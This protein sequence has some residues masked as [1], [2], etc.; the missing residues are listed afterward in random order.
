MKK[1]WNTYTKIDSRL[2]SYTPLQEFPEIKSFLYNRDLEKKYK[3]EDFDKKI[4]NFL[5]WNK[6][7]DFSVFSE[8][9][10]G[11]QF[12]HFNILWDWRAHMLWEFEY[13][14]GIYDLQLK[15]SW[16][17]NYS[18]WWDGKANLS[19]MLREYIISGAMRNLWIPTSKSLW[20]FTTWEE[21]FRNWDM[22]WAILVRIAKS[23]IRVWTFEY[24]SYLQ[25]KELLKK[26]TEYNI[27]RHYPYIKDNKAKYINFIKEVW[28]KQIELVINWLR[29]WFIHGVMNTDNTF[30]SWETIDYWPCA[31]INEYNPNR[32]YSSIDME[33]RYSY[34]NQL[35]I[36]IWNLT[37]FIETLI[38]LLWESTENSI[39]IAKEI[40]ISFKQKAKNDYF[41]M[42]HKKLWIENEN[43]ESNEIVKNFLKILEKEKL[44]YTNTFISLEKFLENNDYSDENIEVLKKW[45]ILWI[46]LINN[47]DE[48]IKIMQK[49]NPKII[50]RNHLVE[51]AINETVNWNMDFLNSFLEVLK[52]PYKNSEN[53]IFTKTDPNDLTHETFCGT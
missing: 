50:P 42:L 6:D 12:G 7:E 52:T 44:D 38:P 24:V 1:F 40:I 5:R 33:W 19:S 34:I 27:K 32:V 21:I 43:I 10:A 2:S 48:S 36:V 53:N 39:D 14:N 41:S 28:N 35:N 46:P 30:I 18:R 20:V 29:L 25:D 9:Y 23:H 3:L 8:A 17:T 16:I 22:K 15:W 49:T 13:K 4:T 26:F 45:I 37:R 31:F 51:K 47:K 11:H